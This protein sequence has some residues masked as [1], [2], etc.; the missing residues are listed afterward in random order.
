[1]NQKREHILTGR[2]T[3]LLFSF[4]APAITGMVVGAL[5]NIVD[6]IFVGKSSG[7]LAIA[8]LSVVF[9]VQ[10]IMMSV[11]IMVGTGASSVMS[12]ALGRND[13]K[14]AADTMGSGVVINLV[15]AVFLTAGT[16][17]FMD[18][19]LVF[20][21]ASEQVLP[22]ARDYLGIIL[23]GFLFYSFSITS[24]NLIRAEGNP[25]A[26][27]Y[28]MLIGA[29]AN[30][31]LDPIFIFVLGMGIRG[32]AVATVIS[33]GISCLYVLAFYIR[34]KS[35]LDIDLS[36]FKLRIPLAKEIF[37]VGLPSF[38]KS[39]MSSVIIL[40]FNRALSYYGN[41]LYIAIMGIGFRLLSLI[42][43]PI[44]GLTQGFSTIAS[45]NYGAEL[46]PRVKRVL[47]AAVLWTTAISAIGFIAV[48]F[49][50]RQILNFFSS[51]PLLVNMG[52]APLR[53]A[54]LFLPFLGVQII[55]GGLFQAIGKPAPAL[56]ITLSRQV[57]FLI[58]AILG[59][60]VLM[61]LDG[62]WYSIPVADFL[63]I[64]VTAAWILKE[65]GLFNRKI[66]YQ[67]RSAY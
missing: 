9:P 47:A 51:S 67:E 7:P 12:R 4:S 33:Q 61:G 25:K 8:A 6:T 13:K 23:I 1:M 66:K 24:N 58:P 34:G 57:L 22:Y 28:V 59:L 50:T 21:G 63:S 10:L 2:I 48:M 41:D 36:C 18:H 16:Y 60:P 26:S 46:L 42:H 35:L 5:Y 30:I 44:V 20:F 45:F 19:F 53:T 65:I 43:M 40:I 17:L 32:A 49:F 38:F 52:V 15:L 29:V 31:I 55:G 27:M 37:S 39:S 14:T 64:S 56:I 62:V 54:V 3:K 11:G